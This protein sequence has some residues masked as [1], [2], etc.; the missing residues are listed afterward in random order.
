M[1]ITAATLSTG[2]FVQHTRHGWPFSLHHGLGA[3]GAPSEHAEHAEPIGPTRVAIE[4]APDRLDRLGIRTEQV[5]SEELSRPVRAVATVVPDET[6]V[7]HVH[8]RVSGWIEKLHV[9]ATGATVRAGQPIAG[10][11]SRELLASQTEYLAVRR[12]AANAPKSA[13]LAGA[14]SRLAVLGMSEEAIQGLEQR[15][16]P[17]R[18]V[19]ITSP[20]RGVVLHRGITVGT[21]VDPS[22]ELVTI[23]DLS[24]VWVF[25]EIPEAD[26]PL[27]TKGTMAALEF[28]AS[29]KPPIHAPV[30]FLYPTLSETTRTLRVRFTVDNPDGALRPGIFGHAD[31][32]ITPRTVLT[33]GR[34]AVVD[35]GAEQHVFIVIGPGRFEP[36]TVE[37]GLRL[38]DRVEVRTGLEEGE[39]VVASGVFLL[40]SESRLR[41]SGGAGTGH[42]HGG[43]APADSPGAPPAHEG[44][45]GHQ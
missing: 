45:G 25:A 10:I 19:T 32:H 9:R 30:E 22:T 16:E 21:A 20:R 38:H 29:G 6:Q 17:R 42:A 18:L 27:V 12:A 4:V 5:R 31:M 11:F 44:H 41:A 15:G 24:R 40:D 23:A 2:L 36:R 13:V 8:A 39:T 7:S 37:L 1:V 33:V 35:T 43:P 26:V 28:P 34:D 3:R 14:R